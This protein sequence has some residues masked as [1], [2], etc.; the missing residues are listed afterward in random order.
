M[1]FKKVEHNSDE[2]FI[3]E[4]PGDSVEGILSPGGIKMTVFGEAKYVMVGEKK[5]LLSGGLEGTL[6]SDLFGLP[7]RVTFD[8]MQYNKKTKRNFK[9][10]TVEVDDGTDA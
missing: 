9:A 5:V 8:G 10:F 1:A 2:F 4:L 3:P 7:V 6:T